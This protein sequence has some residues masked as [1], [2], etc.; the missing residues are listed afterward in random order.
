MYYYYY[1]LYY[2]IILFINSSTENARS[3]GVNVKFDKNLFIRGLFTIRYIV[4][5][6]IL[7]ITV[8]VTNVVAIMTVAELRLWA[9]RDRDKNG[10]CVDEY[11]LN[12]HERLN[13]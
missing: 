12:E 10:T 7:S 5:V 3:Q 8:S 1:N 13:T 6:I 11:Y 9:R 4:R 2:I